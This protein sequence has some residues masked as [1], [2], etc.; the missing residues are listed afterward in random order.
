MKMYLSTL[1]LSEMENG[2]E[3][4]ITKCNE[5]FIRRFETIQDYIST[6]FITDSSG[7]AIQLNSQCDE[8]MALW[9]VFKDFKDEIFIDLPIMKAMNTVRAVRDEMREQIKDKD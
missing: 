2:A 1:F 3:H 8:M 4:A 5:E 9:D 6:A 7:K